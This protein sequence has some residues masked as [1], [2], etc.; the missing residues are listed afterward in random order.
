MTL[1]IRK[2]KDD[3]L[4]FSQTSNYVF[5][6][7]TK[8]GSEAHSIVRR[9]MRQSN[10]VALRGWT[11]SSTFFYSAQLCNRTGI[12]QPNNALNSNYKWLEDINIYEAENGQKQRQERTT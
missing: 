3:I 4:S 11:S 8:P 10:D 7:S 5:V 1:N 9:I 6:R 12:R 2:K